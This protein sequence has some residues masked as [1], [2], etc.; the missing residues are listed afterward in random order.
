MTTENTNDPISKAVSGN[1]LLENAEGKRKLQKEVVVMQDVDKAWKETQ[2]SAF[3]SVKP[4]KH[5][6]EIHARAMPSIFIHV[7]TDVPEN[8]FNMLRYLANRVDAGTITVERAWELFY[9]KFP[10]SWLGKHR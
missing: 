7:V 1:S 4:E 9:D 3:K 2:D 6:R 10:E 5:V 8:Q